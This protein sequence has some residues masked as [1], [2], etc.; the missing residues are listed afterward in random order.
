MSEPAS[1]SLGLDP[2]WLSAVFL[3]SL[4]LGPLFVL[5][6]VFGT[7]DFPVRLRVMLV[8]AFALLMVS[9][10]GSA[11][12]P[13]PLDA[14][15]LLSAAAAELL[16]GS[17][18]GF[19]LLAAFGAF[20]LGG[21]L[22][23]IQIGFGVATLFDPTTRNQSPLLGTAFNLLATVLFFA[24]DGH[25]AIGRAVAE[26]MQRVPPGAGLSHIGVD[27]VIAQFGAMFGYA[28]AL[29]APAMIALLL[30]DVALAVV[31]RTMPQMNIFIVAMPL[32]VAVGLFVMALAM[33][34][35]APLMQRVF[36]ALPAYWRAAVF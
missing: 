33:R 25:H 29:V 18:L 9:A 17:A 35:L 6:P 11:G 3:L 34:E 28:L 4:R 15:A 7:V 16:I 32:K 23:D 26:S 5:A 36:G 1:L 20:Q 2:R 31:A 27:A 10:A 22:L 21:R 8:F 30:L 12:S 19:G 14:G 13:L 24:V